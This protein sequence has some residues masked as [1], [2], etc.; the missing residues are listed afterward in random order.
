LTISKPSDASSTQSTLE[1]VFRRSSWK[2]VAPSVTRNC[3]S[4]ICGV[5]M[6]G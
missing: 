4:R 1:D 5:S 6:V 2:N 3:R